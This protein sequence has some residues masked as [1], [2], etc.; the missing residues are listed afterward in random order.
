MTT[1]FKSVN[2]PFDV[3]YQASGMLAIF[4]TK[5]NSQTINHT[6][7]RLPGY[8]WY[9][10][11]VKGVIRIRK[12]KKNRQHNRQKDKQ[13]STKHTH[14]TTDRVTRTPLKTG[15]K[16][17]CSGRVSSSCSTSG[18]RSQVTWGIVFGFLLL[19]WFVVRGFN[20]VG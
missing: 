11:E 5:A 20:E 3:W 7:K 9:I 12:S 19:L 18:T 15:G 4:M 1:P 17:R 13:R 16:L 10:V 8:N 14:K 6:Y 2:F